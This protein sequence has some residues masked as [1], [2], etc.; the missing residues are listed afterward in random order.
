MTTVINFQE[1]FPCSL[2][3][4]FEYK[5]FYCIFKCSKLNKMNMAGREGK[6]NLR[7]MNRQNSRLLTATLGMSEF[8]CSL[9]TVRS[10]FFSSP[11]SI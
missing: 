11:K 5:N 10:I 8:F 3:R 7:T 1:D 4:S 6:T 9:Y 2:F